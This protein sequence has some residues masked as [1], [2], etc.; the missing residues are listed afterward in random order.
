MTEPQT[1]PTTHA[2]AIATPSA[3]A[4]TTASTAAPGVDD[5]ATDFRAVEGGGE[6]RSGATLMVEAYVVLWL[7]LMA[8]LLTL[9]RK[10]KSLHTRLDDLEKTIDKAAAK[11]EA[12]KS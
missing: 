8:W 1:A 2:I 7:I 5:R 4:A 9:W 12:K 10:Q 11:L 3:A 6:Q